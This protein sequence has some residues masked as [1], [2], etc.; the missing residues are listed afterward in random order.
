MQDKKW[1]EL[2]KPYQKK[3]DFIAFWQIAS[4]T[5]AYA[6]VWYWYSFYAHE[7][8]LWSVPFAFLASMFL[9]RFFVLMHDCGHRAMF[10]KGWANRFFGYF[11]GAIVGMPQYV[12]SKHHSYHHN[13]NGDWEKY[14]G[15]LTT[16]SVGEYEN[17]SPKSQKR[18]WAVRKAP[19]LLPGGFVYI[20]FNP[21]FNWLK[22]L[23]QWALR[24]VSSVFKPGTSTLAQIKNLESRYWKTPKEFWHM[25]YNNLTLI[26]LIWPLMINWLGH[27]A[28]WPMYV[29]SISLAGAFGILFFTLQHNFEDSYA[30]D[31]DRVSF[32]KAALEGTSFLDFPWPLTWFTADI[33]YH[34]IHHLSSTI[35]NYQLKRCHKALSDR[36]GAVTR[37][38]LFEIPKHTNCLLW[39]EVNEKIISRGVY[40]ASKSVSSSEAATTV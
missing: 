9:L 20:L 25:T 27:A 2:L 39:D 29:L 23:V 30:S 1:R 33:G 8:L 4:T 40:E 6:G 3:N 32:E 15:P 5:L 7:S 13:T 16:I 10:S 34:H 11:S 37:I 21:R 12:W 17:L 18:Y 38:G 14:K 31:T 36:F 19:L 26:F 22:G 28:F 24:V 35:P